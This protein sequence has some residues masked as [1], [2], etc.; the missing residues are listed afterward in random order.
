MGYMAAQWPPDDVQSP[1]GEWWDSQDSW[2][3]G[4]DLSALPRGNK[5]GSY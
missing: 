2:V 3:V 1:S 5:V 4:T